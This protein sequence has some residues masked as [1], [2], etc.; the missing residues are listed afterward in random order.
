MV[1]QTS[2]SKIALLVLAIL[3]ATFFRLYE[4]C[5]TTMRLSISSSREL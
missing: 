2:V 4:T 1:S 5:Y 3:I